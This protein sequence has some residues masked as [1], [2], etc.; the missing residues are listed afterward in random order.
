MARQ[1]IIL[2]TPPTGLG[3]D[4]PR[5]ASQ[6]INAMTLELY[7]KNSKL[8]SAALANI[9]G[10]MASGAIIERGSNANG[11][12]TKFAD[13][14][15]ICWGVTKKPNV[16]IASPNG[17]VFNSLMQGLGP[18]AATFV[19]VPSILLSAISS[20]STVW[21]GT[22]TIGTGNFYFFSTTAGVRD[23]SV[24]YTVTGRWK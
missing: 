13:G 24:A 10:P 20:D 7:D 11:E 4:P 5:V 1:E 17:A 9:L 14:T 12:Y 3:G 2:G 19:G 18:T 15:L 8:G 6:K 16:T 21:I 22:P 23:C